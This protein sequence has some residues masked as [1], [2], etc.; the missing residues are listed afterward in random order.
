MGVGM[1]RLKNE[2]VKKENVLSQTSDD[3]ETEKSARR[4]LQQ[5]VKR[6]KEQPS[7]STVGRPWV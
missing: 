4:G 6:L 2:L 3:L 7:A 1:Q 5:E